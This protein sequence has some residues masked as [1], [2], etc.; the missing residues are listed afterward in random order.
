MQRVY[1]KDSADAVM[2]ALAVDSDAAVIPI[3]GYEWWEVELNAPAAGS[4]ATLD[5]YEASKGGTLTLAASYTAVNGNP[6][7]KERVRVG[8]EIGAL[9]LTNGAVDQKPEALVSLI[10]FGER[11]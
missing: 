3:Y 2:V 7:V 1:R 11:T 10:R 9:V 8:G 6:P 4:S 5:V